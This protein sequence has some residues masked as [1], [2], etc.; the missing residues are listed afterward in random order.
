VFHDYFFCGLINCGGLLLIS[1]QPNQRKPPQKFWLSIIDSSKLL[2]NPLTD[3]IPVMDKAWTTQKKPSQAF[4]QPLRQTESNNS[5]S[6][7]YTQNDKKVVVIVIF[8]RMDNH[9]LYMSYPKF[10]FRPKFMMTIA[11]KPS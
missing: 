11:Q 8:P 9:R 10:W 1:L 2:V 5:K 3:L 6:I 4:V 7:I